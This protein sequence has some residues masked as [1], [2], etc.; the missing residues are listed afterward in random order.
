MPIDLRQ[1]VAPEHTAVLTMEMQRGV[2]GDLAA[3]PSIA[4][5]VAAQGI[6]APTARLLAAARAAGVRV[7]HCTAEFR[8]DRAGSAA[9]SPMLAMAYK[10]PTIIV[11]TPG[12]EVIPELDQQPSDLVS[13]R[14]HG[15]RR[16]SWALSLDV[17]LRNL[18]V[19]HGDRDG[20]LDQHRDLRHAAG[21]VDLG[22]SGGA[23]RS[24][25]SAGFPRTTRS[26]CST[27][28]SRSSPPAPP[29]TISSRSGRSGHTQ[30]HSRASV[31]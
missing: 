5:A 9:N 13:T 20:V 10:S 24:T 2:M 7:V 12:V 4:Q 27:T 3:M 31:S 18:G 21:A 19:T 11:G 29:P 17:T 6:V 1:L 16:R 28:P 30:R 26:R 23:R 15:P 8:E 22:Y 25:A 14:F